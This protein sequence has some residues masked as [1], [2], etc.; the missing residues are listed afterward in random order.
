MSESPMAVQPDSARSGGRRN[1]RRRIKYLGVISWVLLPI[2]GV[3]GLLCLGRR[4]L[5]CA[6]ERADVDGCEYMFAGP[7]ALLLVAEVLF[8]LL[9]RE[10]RAFGA[11]S[12]AAASTETGWLARLSRWGE[13]LH[14]GYW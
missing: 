8:I 9:L 13:Q 10:V 5:A 6:S 2:F 1:Y 7:L 3:V 12:G 4:V 14:R 11:E